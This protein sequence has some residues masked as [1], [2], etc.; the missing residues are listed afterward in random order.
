MDRVFSVALF[1]WDL[2]GD[3]QLLKEAQRYIVSYHRCTG[4]YRQLGKHSF[5][6]TKESST[7]MEVLVLAP[8]MF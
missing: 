2:G 7:P 8:S 1:C 5:Q 4:S 3:E 6:L